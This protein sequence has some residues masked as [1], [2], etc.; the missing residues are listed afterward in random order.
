MYRSQRRMREGRAQNSQGRLHAWCSLACSPSSAPSKHTTHHPHAAVIIMPAAHAPALHPT[1][2]A[3]GALG[4]H[5]TCALVCVLSLAWPSPAVQPAASWCHLSSARPS[6]LLSHLCTSHL[7]AL[8]PRQAS[9]SKPA[10]AHSLSRR[11]YPPIV[12]PSACNRPLAEPGRDKHGSSSPPLSRLLLA[13]PCRRVP[14][15]LLHVPLCVILRPLASLYLQHACP[16]RRFLLP[17]P[18]SPVHYCQLLPVTRI[19]ALKNTFFL[20]PKSS[21]RPYFDP[22]AP[23]PAN[24]CSV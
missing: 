18:T 17:R 12:T 11:R 2:P 6:P 15:R 22:L 7:T 13:V 23:A 16:A 3:A 10:S 20:P 14:A 9:L 24:L 21:P 8:C 4:R 19:S 5:P 1:T